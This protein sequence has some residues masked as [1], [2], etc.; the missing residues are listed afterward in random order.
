MILPHGV[1]N[2]YAVVALDVVRI[3]VDGRVTDVL[4]VGTVLL[5]TTDV[6]ANGVLRLVC[7]VDFG[8]CTHW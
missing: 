3:V 7:D 2:G 1:C 6:V 8:S 4:V 5:E